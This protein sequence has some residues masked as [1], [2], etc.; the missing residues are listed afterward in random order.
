[1]NRF[2]AGLPA[3]ERRTV[4]ALTEAVA[5]HLQAW[6]APFGVFDAR[7]F[8]TTGLTMAAA[9]PWLAL[10]DLGDMAAI[11]LWIF[12]V[13]DCLDEG[14][15]G[16]GDRD[17]RIRHYVRIAASAAGREPP[18]EDPYAEALVDIQRRLAARPL[19]AALAGDWA[20][21]CR[22]MLAGMLFECRT[23]EAVRGGRPWPTRRTYLEHGIQ[24]I[25]VPMYLTGSWIICGGPETPGLLPVLRPMARAA[26]RAV[27]LA[28]DLRTLER[29]R[30][31]GNANVLMML[32]AAGWPADRAAAWARAAASA[33]VRRLL[34]LAAEAGDAP[35]V[36]VARR[37][38]QFSVDFYDEHDFHTV[39]RRDIHLV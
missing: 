26:G 9:A 16:P 10:P 11:T 17:R 18:P 25:G 36:R 14:R 3:V 28:N 20:R 22:A 30:T 13:D 39:A 35:A 4:S 37:V 24:S 38:C 32:E 21:T 23:G 15:F 6:A 2:L 5:D 27:R 12:T 8:A 19:Y 7:R 33:S 1:M 29:E 31:E 34:R